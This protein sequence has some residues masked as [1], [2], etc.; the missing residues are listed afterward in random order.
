MADTTSVA[1]YQVILDQSVT[2]GPGTT[3]GTEKLGSFM[4]PGDLIHSGFSRNPIL[5]FKVIPFEDSSLTIFINHREIMSANFSPSHTR[6]F[7]E[8]F[9]FDT[10]FPEGASFGNPAPV[11]FLVLDGQLQIGDAIIWY[12]VD[13]PWE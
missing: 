5:A 11:K 9:S 12:Q 6:I 13:R 3:A 2:L 8:V 10:A 1:D 4:V 7:W